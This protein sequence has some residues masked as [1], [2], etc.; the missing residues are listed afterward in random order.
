M[1]NFCRVHVQGVITVAPGAELD[2]EDQDV[3]SVT[4]EAYD[5]PSTP[6]ERRST[7]AQVT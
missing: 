7:T 3:V 2:R 4:I 5:S 1:V 6:T